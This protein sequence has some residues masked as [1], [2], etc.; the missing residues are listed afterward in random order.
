[1]KSLSARQ[2]GYVLLLTLVMVALVAAGTVGLTR[3]SLASA[4]EAKQAEASLQRRWAAISCRRVLLDQAPTLIENRWEEAIEPDESIDGNGAL[5]VL[6]DRESMRV[7]RGQVRLGE[8]VIDLRLSDE[9]AKVNVNAL[10]AEFDAGE[11][12]RQIE[13]LMGSLNA[14][15]TVDLRPVVAPREPEETGEIQS[16]E[17]VFS[18]FRPERIVTQNTDQNPIDTL[19]CWG[20]GRLRLALASDETLRTLL[21]DHLDADRLEQLLE[22]R[23]ERPGITVDQAMRAMTLGPSQ[24]SPI[25][26]LLTDQSTCYSMWLTIRSEHRAWHELG[27]YNT[28]GEPQERYLTYLW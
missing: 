13:L 2:H 18:D 8:Y 1:M 14:D 10:L 4:T 6:P 15:L 5:Q 26:R 9:Q 23:K 24:S 11:A 21:T 17:R 22:L 28:G 3:T 19:T 25:R 20:D 27:L 12:A 7:I 16:F